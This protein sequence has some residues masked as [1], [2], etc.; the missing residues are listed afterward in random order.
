VIASCDETTALAA[1]QWDDASGNARHQAAEVAALVDTTRNGLRATVY[2][3]EGYS[4]ADFALEQPWE[5]FVVAEFT[6]SFTAAATLI[7]GVTGTSSITRTGDAELTVSAGTPRAIAL[8]A[9]LTGRLILIHA[10][11]ANTTGPEGRIVVVDVNGVEVYEGNAGAQNPG[12][13]LIGCTRAI[14]DPFAGV[15]AELR[16]TV[17]LSPYHRRAHADYLIQKWGIE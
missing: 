11:W 15:V 7:D 4:H 8:D 13:I 5:L 2:G 3:G 1:G 12:G 6:T 14:A 16:A 17:Q 9:S 10:S